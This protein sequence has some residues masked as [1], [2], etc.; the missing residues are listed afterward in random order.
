MQNKCDSGEMKLDS[1]QSQG[2]ET[3]SDLKA[4][5]EFDS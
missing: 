1:I 4:R 2:V 3:T 5:G